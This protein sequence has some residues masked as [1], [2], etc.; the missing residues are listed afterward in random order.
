VVSE[1]R[2]SLLR[3]FTVVPAV[4]LGLLALPATA[5]AAPASP[6][7]APVATWTPDPYTPAP[8]PAA[9]PAP[10]RPIVIRPIVVA[11]AQP[12]R[13]PVTPVR[14]VRHVA[15]AA[16]RRPVSLPHPQRALPPVAAAATFPMSAVT[17]RKPVTAALALAA[18]VVLSSTFILVVAR[19]R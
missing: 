2:Q 6:D 19:T 17:A 5:A 1:R 3:R 18:F 4:V 13:R 12:L 16:Q 11:P 10:A 9:K 7:P 8:R 14:H 15:P